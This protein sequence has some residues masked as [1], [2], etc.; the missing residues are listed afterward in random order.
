MMRAM[1]DLARATKTSGTMAV[2]SIIETTTIAITVP[3]GPGGRD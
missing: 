3:A 1:S 2:I